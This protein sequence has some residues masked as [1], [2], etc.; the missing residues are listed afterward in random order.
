MS[1]AATKP[2]FA[3]MAEFRSSRELLHAI[4]QSR[5]AGYTEIE[6]YTPYPIEEVWEALGQH[7]S[8]LPLIVLIAGILGAFTG[9]F[10]QYWVSVVNYPV[11]VGGRP[12]NRWV[13]CIPVTFETTIL[14]AA[15]AAVLGMF[16][17]NRLPMPYHPVF[18][19]PRF[20][21]ASRD[22]YFLAIGSWDSKYDR[23]ATEEFLRG[24]EPFEVN[25]VAS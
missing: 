3:L 13:S 12:L 23:Q 20:A 2:E 6:A 22:R 16:A 11:N 7:K 1:E 8:K 5:A 17:I 18:N 25:E 10:L 24:L 21:L 19:V 15:V 14:F 9:Y 4:E